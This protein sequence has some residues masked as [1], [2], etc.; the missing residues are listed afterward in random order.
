MKL[1]GIDGKYIALLLLAVVAVWFISATPGCEEV[2]DELPVDPN[3]PVVPIIPSKNPLD[4]YRQGWDSEGPANW[5]IADRLAEMS[6]LAYLAGPA[7][8]PEFRRIGFSKAVPIIKDSMVAYVLQEKDVAI[9]VFRGTDD[10]PDWLVNLDDASTPTAEGG[11]HRGFKLAYD[12][13]RSEIFAS[14]NSSGVKHCWIT[15]HSL[16]G[17]LAVV[18]A[19]DIVQSGVIPLS[20]LITFG[21][22]MVAKKA[23]A[24]YLDSALIGRYAHFVNE[25]DAVPRVPPFFSHCGSLVWFKDGGIKRSKPKRQLFGAA[26]RDREPSV[27]ED[28]AL[29]PMSEAE[30]RQLKRQ[31]QP[32]RGPDGRPIYEGDSPWIRDHSMSL[33]YQKVKSLMPKGEGP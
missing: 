4:V 31:L 18:C 22:P 28:A 26:E 11:V 20:G 21:Q 32:K 10:G 19:Y 24:G 6:E 27:D 33:Y 17:A 3:N 2:I 9:I 29:S 7:A 14:L 25:A 16:G 15:G 5:P 12:S 8:G 1:L 23:L 30:F 13:M